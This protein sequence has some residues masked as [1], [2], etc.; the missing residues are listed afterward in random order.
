MVTGNVLAL[1]IVNISLI[2]ENYLSQCRQ[3]IIKSAS[4]RVQGVILNFLL[5]FFIGAAGKYDKKITETET[6]TKK[7]EKVKKKGNACV[8]GK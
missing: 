3:K 4:R 7:N 2:A 6:K 1:N 5:R 8:L